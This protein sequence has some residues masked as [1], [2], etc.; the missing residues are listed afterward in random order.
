MPGM[1]L[2]QHS[3]CVSGCKIAEAQQ[4]MR[5]A[6]ELIQK[7][8]RLQ[9]KAEA[10]KRTWDRRYEK[11]PEMATALWCDRCDKAYSSK[12]QGRR[13]VS[14]TRYDEDGD[15]YTAKIDLCG[16]CAKGM[17]DR[18]AIAQTPEPMTPTAQ[19]YETRPGT[20]VWGD[21]R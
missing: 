2:V 15:S 13:Q 3:S 9:Q 14:E 17:F 8:T 7:A 18:P 6:Q 19:N 1:N 20:G 4:M 16:P 11:E 5:Q 21:Q 10:N 12:D